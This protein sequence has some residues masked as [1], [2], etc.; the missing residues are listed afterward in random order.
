MSMD[1]ATDT[2]TTTTT[3]N[4]GGPL[5]A[6]ADYSTGFDRDAAISEVRALLGGGE[7][8]TEDPAEAAPA[9]PEA[10]AEAG[11]QEAAPADPAA[12]AADE[13]LSMDD[14][15]RLAAERK[16]KREQEQQSRTQQTGDEESKVAAMREQIAK[17]IR[18]QIMGEIGQ[19]MIRPD[20]LQ[21][22]LA[23]ALAR[24]GIDPKQGIRLLAQSVAG[25]TL[26]AKPQPAQQPT[27]PTDIKSLVAEVL[28]EMLE[29]RLAPKL[30]E[31]EKKIAPL[32]EL[33]T[34]QQQQKVE[35][36]F[37]T[38]TEN[39]EMYPLL[40]K[41]P[42]EQRIA[43]GHQVANQYLDAGME[44][45]LAKLAGT[46][47]GYLRGIVERVTPSGERQSG[48]ST[49]AA[50]G[51]ETNSAAGQATQATQ[52]INPNL[53]AASS[54]GAEDEWSEERATAEAKA[55]VREWLKSQQTE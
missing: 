5:P 24:A 10:P 45:N 31:V 1:A 30:E 19:K 17:E 22:D 55:Y 11:T 38:M 44:F 33:H 40:S 23:G 36:E 52:T 12:P 54:A 43:Y 4:V 14:L 18:E 3:E 42:P 37:R 16:A 2:T 47:E 20:D 28:D 49:P 32:A 21:S 8:T 34:Q 51:A 48:A 25:G 6:P 27:Q 29:G 7:E 15:R 9:E 46:I 50:R 53:Q 35:T 41:L 13:S 26:A 39:G